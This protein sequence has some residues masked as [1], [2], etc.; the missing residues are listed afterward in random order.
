LA[1]AYHADVRSQ[2]SDAVPC[3]VTGN[4]LATTV[5]LVTVHT[6]LG[7]ANL[8]AMAGYGWRVPHALPDT[9]AVGMDKAR[10]LRRP[11]HHVFAAGT[12]PFC[13]SPD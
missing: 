5:D 3:T 11:A 7:H 10:R 4:L 13:R 1:A 8:H 6:L 9:S 12:T 2:L